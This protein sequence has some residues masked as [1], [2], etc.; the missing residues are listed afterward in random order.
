M[1]TVIVQYKNGKQRTVFNVER[2]EAAECE[3][4]ENCI[5]FRMMFGPPQVHA[6]IDFLTVKVESFEIEDSGFSATKFTKE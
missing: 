2:I 1:L 3:N 5:A 6:N 4:Y